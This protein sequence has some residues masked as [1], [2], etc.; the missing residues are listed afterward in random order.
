MIDPVT[1]VRPEIRARSAYSLEQSACRFKLDQNEVPWD[2]PRRFKER[3]SAAMLARD[4]SRYPDFHGDRLRQA[5][6]SR[7][8]HPWEGV[9]VGNGA[10][11]LLGVARS[12]LVPE[13]GEVLTL[14]PGFGLYPTM[15]ARSGGVPR[16]LGPRSD[17][18][19]PIDELEAEV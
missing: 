15:I 8:G 5:L 7:Y 12:A 16:F 6:E 11:E 18:R 3:A 1:F 13:R 10:N 19:L 9:L 17:L 2:L 4:W 14:R